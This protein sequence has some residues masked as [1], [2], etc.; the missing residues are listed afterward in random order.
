M[1]IT[2]NV[3]LMKQLNK[4]LVINIIRDHRQIS[5]VDIARETGLNRSTVTNLVRELMDENVVNTSQAEPKYSG[6]RRAEILELNY[7]SFKIV[8]VNIGRY[9]TTVGL[10]DIDANIKAS[11]SFTTSVQALS[12]IH[13]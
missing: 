8:V 5:R 4:S 9:T 3:E 11:R 6:G 12:L 1:Y 13:I 7:D 2:G 10:V